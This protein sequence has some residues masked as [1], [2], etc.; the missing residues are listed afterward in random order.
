MCD[1][2]ENT[3]R[4]AFGRAIL[5]CIEHSEF[6]VQGEEVVIFQYD[7][8]QYIMRYYWNLIGFF[9]L[10]QGPSSAVETRIKEISDEF[11]QHS[12]LEYHVWYDKIEQFLKRNPIHFER[13]IKKF[14]TIFQQQAF[15][16][17]KV[18]RTDK[19]DL[20]VIDR[21]SKVLR[22]L[23]EDIEPLQQQIKKIQSIIDFQWAKT[24][25]LYNKSPN[26]IHKV[27][28]SKELKI[29]RLNLIK[30]RNVLLQYG[31]LEGI[32]D[33]YTGEHLDLSEIS[34]EHVI[35]FHFIYSVDIWN[36]VVVSKH[37]IQKFRGRIPTKEDIIKLEN[38]NK[39][40]LNLMKNTKLRV[41]YNLERAE[42]E[43]LLN[44]YFIDL[45]G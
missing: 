40:L 16:R 12:S 6:E 4:F 15:A 24:L 27:I 36:L 18:K 19:L 1:D 32:Q 26:I 2:Q 44:R 23:Q 41:R 10:N 13:E 43:H 14:I 3:Y 42:S 8:I 38:R 31:H 37:N 9:E 30:Y 5:E 20:F 28:G 22:F 39:S 21:K 29:K 34:L 45:K 35:P 25:E 11:Y 7:V 33:F 17:F